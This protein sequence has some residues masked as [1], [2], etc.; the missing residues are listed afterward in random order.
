MLYRLTGVTESSL[1]AL[2]SIPRIREKKGL[3]PWIQKIIRE[4]IGDKALRKIDT[5]PVGTVPI[6]SITM[7]KERRGPRYRAPIFVAFDIAR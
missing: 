6:S 4:L 3:I 7:E 5:G 2:V 1:W